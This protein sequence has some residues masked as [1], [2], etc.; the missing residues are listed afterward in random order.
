MRQRDQDWGRW[1]GHPHCPGASSRSSV[2]QASGQLMP[3][4]LEAVKVGESV[5]GLSLVQ[6]AAAELPPAPLPSPAA[7]LE[8]EGP[9]LVLEGL[10]VHGPI[11]LGFTEGLGQDG[12][13][14][15]IRGNG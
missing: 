13:G 7:R 14:Q 8:A 9:Q 2:L 12:R 3:G 4:P 5:V 6:Q 15:S 1:T 11:V 10:V